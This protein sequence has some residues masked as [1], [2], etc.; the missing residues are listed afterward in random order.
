MRGFRIYFLFSCFF[1]LFSGIDAQQLNPENFLLQLLGKWKLETASGKYIIEHWEKK[2]EDYFSGGSKNITG[3]SGDISATEKLSIIKFHDS[4]YYIAHPS[5]NKY[6]TLFRLEECSDTSAVFI[7]SEHD[8]PQIIKYTFQA[9]D[10]LLAEIS[11]INNEN[12][13]TFTF[14]K[15]AG[16]ND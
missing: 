7:N 9:Q 5:Q 3:S 1:I 15:I 13:I 6:P 10:I 11:G 12:L 4:Y 8:F 14:R 16:N 2:G